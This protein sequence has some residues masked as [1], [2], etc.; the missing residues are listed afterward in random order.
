M[1]ALYFSVA[2]VV[3]FAAC[4]DLAAEETGREPRNIIESIKVNRCKINPLITFESSSSLDNNVNGP[5]VI[6]V[7]SWIKDPLGK[8][9]MYFAHH[10]GKYIRLAYA[11]ALEGPW[12]IYEPGTLQLKEAKAFRRHIASPDVHVDEA[13]KEIRMYFHGP[14][15]GRKGQWTGVAISKDGLKFDA[16][17]EILGKFYFRVF[18]WNGHYYAIA[19]NGNSGWGELYRSRDGLTPFESRGNF[20]RMMRHCAVLLRNNQLLIFYSRKGDAPERI[21]V[22]T[23]TLT[24]DWKNWKESPP[25]DVIQPEKEYEGISFPNKASSYGSAIEVRQLRDP[26]IFEEDGRTYLFYTVAGEMGIALAEIEITMKDT[27]EQINQPD[28]IYISDSRLIRLS[29]QFSRAAGYQKR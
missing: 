17:S 26:C 21:V 27:V 1:K 9:Y 2:L 14:A 11:D 18:H 16:P 3:L 5:S 28:G 8:Y 6:R 25:I 12:K 24:D 29:T 10:G 15:K 20:V 7:P 22:A 13:K 23:V 19:K 4:S